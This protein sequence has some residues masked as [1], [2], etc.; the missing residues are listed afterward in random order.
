MTLNRVMPV[1]LR[2]VTEIGRIRVRGRLP[3]TKKYHVFAINK[4]L[5]G[6]Q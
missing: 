5:T 4:R 3:M 6:R 2:Y 1:I